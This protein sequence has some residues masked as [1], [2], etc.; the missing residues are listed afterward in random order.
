MDEAAPHSAAAP[1]EAAPQLAGYWR[2]MARGEGRESL[3]HAPARPPARTILLNGAITLVGM[4][5]LS[6]IEYGVF[7]AMLDR[8]DLAMLIGSQ[9]AAAVLVFDAH[10]APLARPANVIGGNVLS[11]AVGVTVKLFVDWIGVAW[12]GPSLAVALAIMLMDLTGTLHPP[13]GATALIAVI[14]S[15]KVTALGYWYVLCPVGLGA[16]LLT[17][18]AIV[19]NNAFA[20]RHYPLRL[21]P[22]EEPPA[23]KASA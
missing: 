23:E 9:G 3:L 16:V 22:P 6:L 15:D 12:L 13:G 17:A 14:G 1:V 8:S 11:A 18:I 4:L 19:C 5:P 7:G 20:D 10:K 21:V 2:R